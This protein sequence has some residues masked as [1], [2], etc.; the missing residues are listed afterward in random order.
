MQ[1]IQTETASQITNAGGEDGIC[2]VVGSAGHEF[3]LEIP[4]VD[5]TR[6]KPDRKRGGSR[7]RRRMRGISSPS[8]NVEVVEFLKPSNVSYSGLFTKKKTLLRLT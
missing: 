1:A 5:P 3:T 8:D 7:F 6:T 2:Q 4:S